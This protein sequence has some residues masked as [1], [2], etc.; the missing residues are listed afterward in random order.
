MHTLPAEL[1][2]QAL[3]VWT[4]HRMVHLELSDGRELAFPADR[5]ARLRSASD[6]QMAEVTLRLHGQ[7]LRWEALDEDITVRGVVEGRFQL[8]LPERVA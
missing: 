7:A 8:P 3:R 5:F 2:V 1:A 4:H 6:A